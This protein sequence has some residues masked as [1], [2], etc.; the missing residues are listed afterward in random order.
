MVDDFL[1][2]LLLPPPEIYQSASSLDFPKKDGY[3]TA[4]DSPNWGIQIRDSRTD[5]I[6]AVYTKAAV[7]YL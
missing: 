3:A 1:S 2:K 5:D 4:S 6:I 7:H